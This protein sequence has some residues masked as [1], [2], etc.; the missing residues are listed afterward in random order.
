[1]GPATQDENRPPDP[2]PDDPWVDDE[3]H[4]HPGAKERVLPELPRK[5]R[6]PLVAAAIGLLATCMLSILVGIQSPVVSRT[7]ATWAYVLDLLTIFVGLAAI[8]ATFLLAR[9][10]RGTLAVW[11]GE[12]FGLLINAAIGLYLMG[13]FDLLEPR[14]DMLTEFAIGLAVTSG[15]TLVCGVALI[16]GS[17]L[18]ADSVQAGTQ[19]RGVVSPHA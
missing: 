5:G 15:V 14:P 19:A 9:F 11:L 6:V 8:Y 12:G 3:G 16:I 7:L 4:I 2:P 17:I 18:A 1:M 10:P 13:T